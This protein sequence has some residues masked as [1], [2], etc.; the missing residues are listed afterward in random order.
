[1]A[2]E[3]PGFSVGTLLAGAD[4]SALQYTLVKIGAG[5]TVIACTALGETVFGV[6]QN[7]PTSG[8]VAEVMTLGVT[9]I[10]A[11]AAFALGAMLMT[12][13]TGKAATAATAGSAKIGWAMEAA[14][15]DGDI[16]TAYITCGAGIV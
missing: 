6:L 11:N 1:M 13:T 4:L 15:A 14:G 10:K 16:V 7:K 3:Q 2:T 8:L 5:G 9:K 12:A